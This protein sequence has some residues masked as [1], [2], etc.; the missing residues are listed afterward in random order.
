MQHTVRE[1]VNNFLGYKVEMRSV[2]KK[3]RF[4]RHVFAPISYFTMLLALTGGAKSLFLH[5]HFGVSVTKV[6]F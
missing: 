6:W 2:S 5:S 1:D 3:G 4:V